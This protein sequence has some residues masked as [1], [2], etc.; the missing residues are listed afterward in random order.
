MAREAELEDA[1]ATTEGSLDMIV[2]EKN[3]GLSGK[4]EGME[5]KSVNCTGV[6]DVCNISSGGIGEDIF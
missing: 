3:G 2:G 5:R 4:G 6:F 1:A